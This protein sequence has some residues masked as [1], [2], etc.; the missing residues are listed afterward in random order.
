MFV[1]MN[2]LWYVYL[3]IECESGL[4]VFHGCIT[5]IFEFVSFVNAEV[6]FL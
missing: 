3:L 6:V 2:V 1:V 5:H 4:Y